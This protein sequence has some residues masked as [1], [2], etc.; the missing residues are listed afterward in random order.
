MK[1]KNGDDAV[2]RV[3]LTDLLERLHLKQGPNGI[4]AFTE[5]IYPLA[6]EQLLA[7]DNV[8]V[9]FLLQIESRHEN[10][11]FS[12]FLKYYQPLWRGFCRRDFG[13]DATPEW[14]TG[15][16]SWRSVYAWHSYFFRRSLKELTKYAK[17]H[18]LG[19]KFWS[20]PYSERGGLYYMRDAHSYYDANHLYGYGLANVDQMNPV[21][22]IRRDALYFLVALA[23]DRDEPVEEDSFEHAYL[24]WYAETHAADILQ[25]YYDADW[26]TIL[27][28]LP[29]FPTNEDGVLLVG[30]AC[31]ACGN[32]NA[33]MQCTGCNDAIYCNDACQK[34]H[35][36]AHK[37]TE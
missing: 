7:L 16:R 12:R 15:E 13:F 28:T 18:R 5:A 20:V 29:E 6:S 34:M 33:V 23:A 21:F 35:W 2:I 19:H 17:N 37:C 24:S 25:G 9:A 3:G 27:P 22:A 4:Y 14:M 1:R 26:R 31:N 30:N 10:P 32:E 36:I 11:Y 8:T